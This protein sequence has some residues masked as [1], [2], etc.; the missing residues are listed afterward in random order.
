[1]PWTGAPEQ[2]EALE[3]LRQRLA[4]SPYPEAAEDEATLR[5]F[6][7][8]RKLDVEEA[9]EKLIKML[10]W[11]R[12]FGADFI[13]WTDVARE[14][15]TGKAYLHSHLDVSGR[16]VIVVRAAK[17]LT[18]A[19]NL[20]DSQR[21]CVHLM[22]RAL[23]RL[24]SANASSQ[25]QEV[26]TVLGIFDLRGFT[27]ANADWGFVRFLVD[28]FFLYYPKRLSQVL[29]VEAPWVFKP[30]WEI[31]KPWLKKYAALVR[32]VNVDEVRKEY[33]TPETVP[34]DFGGPG[35]PPKPK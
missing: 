35:F 2:L 9:E 17:H 28:I 4:A 24:E 3:V 25:G 21:L 27:S 8:D 34:E 12:E 30:G 10:R 22:D 29:F 6:L 31:V 23:E 7:Q 18:D 20:Q 15:A 33:F 32:F 5:W 1:M 13:S 26:Q 16:P 19:S 11:R 14:A